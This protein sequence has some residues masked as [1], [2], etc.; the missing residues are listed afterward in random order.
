MS[1]VND[2]ALAPGHRVGGFELE[3]VVG[4][5]GFGITYRAHDLNLHRSVAIKE[6]F[7]CEFACRSRDGTTVRPQSAELAAPY[8]EGLKVFMDEART[9]AKFRHPSIVG[10][11]QLLTASNTAYIVMDFEQGQTLL[12]VARARGHLSSLRMG[13]VAQ[14]ILSG[15]GAVHAQAITHCDITPRNI[16]LRPDGSAVLID[17]GA[18]RTSWDSGVKPDEMAAYTPSYAAPE[19]ICEGECGPWTDL[20]SLGAV[21][22]RCITGVSPPSAETRR[23]SPAE[24]GNVDQ[25]LDALPGNYPK[26]LVETVRWMLRLEID[27]RP[28]KAEE[29]IDALNRSDDEFVQGPVEAPKAVVGQRPAPQ[30]AARSRRRRQASV[31]R[32]PASPSEVQVLFKRRLERLCASGA[33]HV[34]ATATRDMDDDQLLD[35]LAGLRQDVAARERLI[36]VAAVHATDEAVADPDSRTAIL[37]CLQSLA[38]AG[39]GVRPACR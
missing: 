22:F 13:Q 7:P 26:S 5:G 24:P 23:S 6:F 21:M 34:C 17:F 10:V 15:L 3:G 11:S 14:D 20:Y 1:T 8:R 27:Q 9:L 37:H 36:A 19:V 18:A 2:Q 12:A 25:V 39:G 33:T 29:V 38:E 35:C 16:I 28:Q 32:A 4:D 31:A 30:A